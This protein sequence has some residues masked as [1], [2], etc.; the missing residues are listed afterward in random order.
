MACDDY[1]EF[2]INVG[3]SNDTTADSS[4]TGGSYTGNNNYTITVTWPRYCRKGKLMDKSE[5]L[6]CKHNPDNKCSDY[7]PIP[8]NPNPPAPWW[9][10]YPW[11]PYQPYQP[12]YGPW[13]TW[14]IS[15]TDGSDSYKTGDDT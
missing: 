12:Y 13:V 3:A 1:V 11:Y 15:T 6:G 4:T 2:T 14:Q 7:E 8:P 5:C 9:P 10:W